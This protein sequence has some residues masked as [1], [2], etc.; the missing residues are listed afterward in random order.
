MCI[1]DRI[2]S[3]PVYVESADDASILRQ[4]AQIDVTAQYNDNNWS[5]ISQNA[6]AIDSITSAQ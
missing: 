6:Y 5:I 3:V 2:Y 1:R 4:I